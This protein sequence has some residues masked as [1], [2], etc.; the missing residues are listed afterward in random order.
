M[1]GTEDELQKHTRASPMTMCTPRTVDEDPEDGADGE[2][3]NMI[4]AWKIQI[5]GL[6]PRDQWNDIWGLLFPSD[7]DIPPCDFEPVVEHFE[8]NKYLSESLR[9]IQTALR[10]PELGVN[11]EVTTRFADVISEHF[12]RVA[13]ARN[14]KPT[15]HPSNQPHSSLAQ[16]SEYNTPATPTSMQWRLI[17]D[18]LTALQYDERNDE[19]SSHPIAQRSVPSSRRWKEREFSE[20]DESGSEGVALNE[21]LNEPALEE[22][23]VPSDSIIEE[24]DYSLAQQ[25]EMPDEEFEILQTA[26][27][28]IFGATTADKTPSPQD[29]KSLI[30]RFLKGIYSFINRATP[31]HTG[32]SSGAALFSLD[33]ST[34][35]GENQGPES[36]KR[37]GVDRQYGDANDDEHIPDFQGT[38][39]SCP[40]R[41]RNPERFNVRNAWSCSMSSFRSISDVRQHIIKVHTRPEPPVFAC[42]R[43]K[44]SFNSQL[45]LDSHLQTLEGCAFQELDPLE[46]INPKTL[47]MFTTTA[48]RTERS[49]LEQWEDL[50][51]GLFPY[52]DEVKTP[53]YQPVLEHFQLKDMYLGSLAELARAPLGLAL[54]QISMVEDHF[55]QVVSRCEYQEQAIPLQNDTSHRQIELAKRSQSTYMTSEFSNY[56]LTSGVAAPSLLATSSHT[57]EQLENM[58][59]KAHHRIQSHDT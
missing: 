17:A 18:A 40:Y 29:L 52:D 36:K 15:S 56:A 6:T 23:F 31:E 32:D 37:Q 20:D 30:F 53:D 10:N 48:R 47:K 59:L 25:D 58:Y 14:H 41:K 2:V 57:V 45:E 7:Q 11:S 28:V 33:C 54:K 12:L 19:P 51:N 1:F 44:Q 55:L 38:K 16:T 4:L 27:Q 13:E 43:C 8:V 3:I 24:L 5:A 26:L 35:D 34:I 50:W 42:Q 9:H 49:A 22:V 21:S 39:F 46:G